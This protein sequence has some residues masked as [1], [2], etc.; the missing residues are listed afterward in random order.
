MCSC[1]LCPKNTQEL[2]RS[3]LFHSK[4]VSSNINDLATNRVF[5]PIFMTSWPCFQW[6]EKLWHYQLSRST[7]HST[8]KMTAITKI[9]NSI[10]LARLRSVPNIQSVW[11]GRHRLL[12]RSYVGRCSCRSMRTD[13]LSRSLC[14]SASMR[15]LRHTARRQQDPRWTDR[16]AG[17]YWSRCRRAQT[18]SRCR[19]FCQLRCGL[20]E[21]GS[22]RWSEE[23]EGRG[24]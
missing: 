18:K 21:V 5:E 11:V 9:R 12:R 15:W 17:T 8:T 14:P 4:K 20:I 24:T 2:V 1:C 7:C 6:V 22:L 23:V 10:T 13:G 16:P 19:C 3:Q